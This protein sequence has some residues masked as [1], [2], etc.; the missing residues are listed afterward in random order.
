MVLLKNLLINWK[1][2]NTTCHGDKAIV[3]L[4]HLKYPD[5]QKDLLFVYEE[6]GWRVDITMA[7]LLGVPQEDEDNLFAYPHKSK[8]KEEKE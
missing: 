5:Y 8:P 4:Q 7:Q 2:V 3:I 1:V 6:E